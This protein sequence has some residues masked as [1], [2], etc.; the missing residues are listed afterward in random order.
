MNNKFYQHRFVYM[1]LSISALPF[2]L[3]LL[4][5]DFSS[6][7]VNFSE[8]RERIADVT[9]DD[10]F[11]AVKG[12]LHHA[13]MEWTAV[14]IA[15]IA[16]LAT[17][18]HY[19]KH[20]DVSVPIIGLAL[21]CAGFI[22]AFHTLAATRVI[23]ANVP[24]VDFIPFTWAFSRTFNASL[25]LVAISISFWLRNQYNF[26]ELDKQLKWQKAYGSNKALSV[27]AIAFVGLSILSVLL[28]ATSE[29]LPQTI[30]KQALITRPFDVLPFGLFAVA[31]T[32]GLRWYRRAPSAIRYAL[33][34]SL[35]PEL[36]AQLHMT[37][38]ST[39]LFDNDFNIAHV[40]KV[41][42]YGCLLIGILYS[43]FDS[44]EVEKQAKDKPVDSGRMKQ[45]PI[46]SKQLLKVGRARYPLTLVIP[47]FTF[48]LVI[49]VSSVTT[50][51]YVSN[52]QRLFTED[53]LQQAEDESVYIKDLLRSIYRRTEREI[54]FLSKTLPVQR[55]IEAAGKNDRALFDEWY[56]RLSIIFKQFLGG[57]SLFKEVRMVQ[58]TNQTQELLR[59]YRHH[60]NVFIMPRSKL[61][62]ELNQYI[63]ERTKHSPGDIRFNMEQSRLFRERAND[64]IVSVSIPIYN[65]KENTAFGVI[66]MKFDLAEYIESYNF[67]EKFDKNVFIASS[68][69]TIIHNGYEGRQLGRASSNKP[70]LKVMFPI[71]ATAIEKNR[72]LKIINGE[73]LIP[74]DEKTLNQR[75]VTGVYRTV[76]L[77]DLSSDNYFRILILLNEQ[78]IQGAIAEYRDI[79][80]LVGFGMAILMLVA[81]IIFSRRLTDPMQKVINEFMR[82]EYTGKVKELPVDATDETGVFARTFH[83]MLVIQ[84]RKD[85]ELLQQKFTLDEHAIVSI[86][87]VK[88][89]ITYV[90]EKFCVISGFTE[91]ELLGQNHRLLN[92]GYHG[93]DFFRDMFKELIQGITWNGEICNKNKD[94][95]NY[96]VQTTIVPFMNE[97]GK[98]ESYISIRTDI[99]SGKNVALELSKTRDI[100]SDQLGQL[101]EA[102]ADLDQ[103]AYVASHDLKSPLNGINQLVSWIEE[104]C[105]DILPEESKEHLGLL[106]SRSSRML[107]L[108]NDLLDYSRIG[109]DDEDKE[110]INLKETT[111]Q[112]FE[113]Q[114]CREGF[115]CDGQDVDFTL[116]RI[117]FEMVLRNLISNV[118]KHHDKKEGK[119]DV[120]YKLV[121]RNGRKLH[122]VK[123]RDD[124][125]G[126]HPEL[127]EKAMEMFQ[128]LQSRDETEGSGMGLAMVKKMVEKYDGSLM[129]ESDGK[130]GATFIV[131]WGV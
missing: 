122:Q 112:L 58:L 55:M 105:Q 77:N 126:I 22:D 114:G 79:S 48:A 6:Q 49:L 72:A 31:M 97:N 15:L 47:A 89:T 113:L 129:I 131:R 98:P 108:L 82:Y 115:V 74:V 106:K 4:G 69:G 99:T 57:D 75:S 130:R 96:W 102:N 8:L 23:S 14:S 1:V 68:E 26:G 60:E 61:T 109:R 93:I 83:N 35:V 92:S 78:E 5:V 91:Q 94:G 63:I 54:S 20:H 11:N 111:R 88:G 125:P 16:G 42:A 25:I 18:M 51:I 52:T 95:D 21:L 121:N 70:Q 3:N 81:G 118:I 37:F 62:T 39:A 12:G 33:V 10:K 127:Q 73:M 59:A 7:S 67:N 85:L 71:L 117:P 30:F 28:A 64:Y 53:K 104:D 43:I 32:V 101:Q 44:N 65:E 87:D 116:E 107:N 41:V 128:T 27:V 36:V 13:L 34:L 84:R 17:F 2:I 110:E 76:I 100:L 56:L 46:I 29:S 50:S 103:F 45:L 38:G 86:T 119:I 124:G 19:Q 123:V 66:E 80:Y 120:S 90:N 9:A 24:N 40:L